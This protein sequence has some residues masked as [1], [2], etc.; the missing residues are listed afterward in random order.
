V[1]SHSNQKGRPIKRH[2]WPLYCAEN[3]CVP[4]GWV[5]SVYICIAHVQVVN[6][7][8]VLCVSH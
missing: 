5:G 6:L 8:S 4:F 7:K 1:A 3:E 2:S